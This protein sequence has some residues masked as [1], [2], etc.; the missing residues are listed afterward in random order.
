[1]RMG[2]ARIENA[3]TAQPGFD[4]SQAVVAMVA[5]S[6]DTNGR[7][8]DGAVNRLLCITIFAGAP[9]GKSGRGRDPRP[10]P[11]PRAETGQDRGH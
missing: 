4:V 3:R 1:M 2:E 5:H 6:I 8:L 10:H 7:D 11:R 9:L